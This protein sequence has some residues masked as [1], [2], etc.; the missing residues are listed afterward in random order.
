MVALLAPNPV[1]DRVRLLREDKKMSQ[2]QL[3]IAANV[4]RSWISMLETKGM[5]EYGA[6]KLAAVARV[7]GVTVEEL[8][9]GTKAGTDDLTLIAMARRIQ[10]YGKSR[11]AWVE[12]TLDSWTSDDE[13][14][15]AVA[16]DDTADE[17][18]DPERK[19][20]PAS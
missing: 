20:P 15:K 19:N 4:D 1:G 7:F 10:R 17:H 12:Q 5:Q 9:Y 8:L 18:D 2:A 16:D 13:M 6:K 11:M 14:R 3:A